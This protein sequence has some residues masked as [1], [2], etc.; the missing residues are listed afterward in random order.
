MKKLDYS[1]ISS[2]LKKLILSYLNTVRNPQ[3]LV[4]QIFDDPTTGSGDQESDP[5]IG[6]KVAQRV[7]DYRESTQNKKIVEIEEL[8]NIIGFGQD[9]LND[10][11]FT[12]TRQRLSLSAGQ[13]NLIESADTGL[14]T[15]LYDHLSSTEALYGTRIFMVYDSCRRVSRNDLD[16]TAW[17]D[18]TNLSFVDQSIFPCLGSILDKQRSGL[19]EQD[20]FPTLLV[21]G[22]SEDFFITFGNSSTRWNDDP[23]PLPI[24]S[25]NFPVLFKK[26]PEPEGRNFILWYDRD[27]LDTLRIAEYLG[28]GNISTIGTVFT[29]GGSIVT[30]Q[31]ALEPSHPQLKP[32]VEYVNENIVIL[33]T[34]DF[35][36]GILRISTPVDYEDLLGSWNHIEVNIETYTPVPPVIKYF[37]RRFYIFY[38]KRGVE[39]FIHYRFSESISA[40]WSEEFVLE[41]DSSTEPSRVA[42]T[43]GG[44]TIARHDNRLVVI[45]ISDH[46]QDGDDNRIL[47]SVYN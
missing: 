29:D 43:R 20:I 7:I 22:F 1:K 47:V 19:I 18:P 28:Q 15:Y 39:N 44:F 13:L 38:I 42:G 12:I 40:E 31:N 32:S 3:E 16:P 33:T 14:S 25:C 35:T 10:L 2:L 4:E 11:A 30:C 27:Q 6:F 26:V 5:A 9:K 45:W 34:R 8:N 17:T 46:L 37:A 24:Q 36:E 23:I 21:W 41:V